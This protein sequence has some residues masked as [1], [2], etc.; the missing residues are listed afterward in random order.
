MTVSPGSPLQTEPVQA[1]EILPFTC[2]YCRNTL[3]DHLIVYDFYAGGSFSRRVKDL[4]CGGCGLQAI[5]DL[6]VLTEH[7]KAVRMF[8][9]LPAAFEGGGS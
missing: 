2:Q 6:G 3:A 4:V 8:R 1:A 5:E 7:A 9:L